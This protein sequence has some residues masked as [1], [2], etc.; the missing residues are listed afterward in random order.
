VVG[1]DRGNVHGGTAAAYLASTVSNPTGFV[2]LTQAIRADT[3]RGRRLR[4][5]GWLRPTEVG[6]TGAGAWMRVD[7]PGATLA[8]DNMSNRPILGTGGWRQ[9]S[10]V[11]DVP[12]NAIGIALGML[13]SGGGDLIADDFRLDIV[14]PEIAST[15]LYD[16]PVPNNIDSAATAASYARQAATAVDLDFE[17]LTNAALSSATIGW[18]AKTAVP[19]ATV[20]PGS[21]ESDLGPLK[22]MIGSASLVGMGEDT[23]GTREFFQMKHRV[24]QYLVHQMGFTHFAIE[25][26]WPEANDMN[27]YVLTGKGD[28]NVLLSNMYFWTWRT[29]EVLDLVKWMRSWNVTA[30][31]AQ[32]VQFLGFDMQFPGAAMDTVAGFVARVDSAN[33]GFVTQRY[34]CLGP[35][36][37]HGATSGQSGATYAALP[38]ATRAAC[39]A[40][41][42]QVSDLFNTKSAAYQAASSAS[43]FANAQHSARLVEQWEDM[44]SAGPAG[45]LLRDKY[46]AENIQW[47]RGQAGVGA[48]MMLWAHNYH[49]S[50]VPNAMGSYLRT[51]YGDGYVNAGFVFGTGGFNA[52]GGSGTNGALQPFQATTVPDG[53]IESA[54][55]GI[56]QARALFDARLI[57]AGGAPAAPL[58][59][60]IRMRSIGA[61]FSPSQELNFFGMQLFP[62]DFDLLIYLATTTPSTILPFVQ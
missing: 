37:N 16:A 17:G 56:S 39:A 15:S 1:L 14:G 4:W 52:V 33:N 13:L 6:G 54:F 60:P 20:V 7:G 34:T 48:K 57:A 49:V 53:S 23:H 21:D 11:L 29:Q 8:F 10:V 27:T 46:M 36:R 35:Y 61:V 5:S 51:A 41:L 2:T 25:A 38:S 58:A 50:S 43:L 59:G 22:Q 30:P 40:G 31:P 42:K 28:P 62:G 9:V 18:L 12:S 26:T 32:R 44:T 47:L 55:G 24:F 3:Y 45:T 19:F